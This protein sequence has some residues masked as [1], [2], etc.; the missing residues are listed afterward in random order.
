MEPP[1]ILVELGI[2]FATRHIGDRA[3][4]L[5][6]SI[7]LLTAATQQLTASGENT[8][9]LAFAE[10]NLAISFQERILGNQKGNNA[11]A[12]AAYRRVIRLL[13]KP[14]S[15]PA[16]ELCGQAMGNLASVLMAEQDFE[17][18]VRWAERALT[19]QEKNVG[20][21]AWGVTQQNLGSA[22]QHR[23]RGSKRRNL[24]RAIVAFEAA[25]EVRTADGPEPVLRRRTAGSLAKAQ[26]DLVALGEPIPLPGDRDLVRI[27][28]AHQ[29]RHRE[30]GDEN[31]LLAAIETYEQA[32]TVLDEH[33]DARAWGGAMHNLAGC[34][35]ERGTPDDVERAIELLHASLRV[36]TREREPLLWAQTQYSLALVYLNAQRRKPLD[37][38]NAA[39]TAAENALELLTQVAHPD[40]W[41]SASHNL[42]LALLTRHDL[43]L[44]RSDLLRG[45]AALEVSATHRDGRPTLETMQLHFKLGMAYFRLAEDPD[46]DRMSRLEARDL[47][48][49]H[50]QLAKAAL[51]PGDPSSTAL[52]NLVALAQSPRSSRDPGEA[53]EQFI[54]HATV[55]RL[56]SP[57]GRDAWVMLKTELGAAYLRRVAGTRAQN[58]ALAVA[59]YRDA[60]AALEPGDPVSLCGRVHRGLADAHR[61]ADAD[62]EAVAQYREVLSVY[63]ND[64]NEDWEHVIAQALAQLYAVETSG[65]R[66]RQLWSSGT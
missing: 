1:E 6:Q 38:T 57:E 29:L 55:A 15:E 26:A 59:A 23:R 20:P 52:D 25:L 27:A 35:T 63:T 60:L 31:A 36:R 24:E 19:V 46:E 39:V 8:Y 4:N 17:R 64:P 54:A 42:G 37:R 13:R 44:D 30:T 10:Y 28:T 43:T 34:Y 65:T 11:A 41:R 32:L 61:A 2:Q 21:R 9:L 16:R 49:Q 7:A 50:F 53:T 48:V 58:V 51:P 22:Y 12:I 3:E 14:R 40:G 18:A 33:S 62:K 66:R 5:E 45:V 56:D 47:T